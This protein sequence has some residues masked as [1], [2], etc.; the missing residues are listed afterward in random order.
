MANLRD[1]NETI[2]INGD[3]YLEDRVVTKGVLVYSGTKII[4]IIDNTD[5]LCNLKN[6]TIINATGKKVLPGLIDI[7]IH[8]GGGGDTMDDDPTSIEKI[9]KTH[10]RYGTTG[11]CLT[12]VS[13]EYMDL[14]KALER[15]NEFNRKEEL[16]GSKVLG[17]HI[18]GPMLNKECCGAHRKQFLIKSSKDLMKVIEVYADNKIIKL[19]T[20]A[21]ELICDQS[22]YDILMNKNITISIG[23][24][25]AS[26]DVII[27][28]LKNGAKSFTHFF[29]AMKKFHHR[30]PNFLGAI[31]KDSASFVEII[32]DG[33]L[34]H[35][36]CFEILYKIVGPDRIVL[37]T[38][39]LKPTGTNTVGP[40]KFSGRSLLVNKDHCVLPDGTIWGSVLTMNNALKNFYNNTSCSL[41]EAIKMSSLNP[42]K[43]LGLHHR[44][45]SLKK[46]KDAD[47]ILIDKDFNVE[48]TIVEGKIVFANGDNE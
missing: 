13:S 15:I 4:N 12:T 10:A 25:N 36:A 20:L 34:V 9:T 6:P 28:A 39:A 38:D 40:F 45:G 26:F 47:I 27:E 11:L 33:I 35:P 23:H 22:I 21:P 18:E 31:A 42:A 1:I 43:L 16:N 48:M 14:I 5:S 41:A 24:S 3:I 2:V 17:A 29:N 30:E 19:I 7:H 44:K 46:G 8:G 37:I 32:A